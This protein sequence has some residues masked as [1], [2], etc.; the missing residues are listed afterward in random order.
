MMTDHP[1]P[2]APGRAA[3]QSA[4]DRGFF[5]IMAIAITLTVVIGF[6]VSFARPQTAFANAPWH[7]HLHAAVFSL[8]I[9]LY[10]LQN[11]LVVRGGFGLHRA[12]GVFGAG[13]VLVMVAVGIHTTVMALALHRVPPFFPPGV[14]LVLDVT[15]VL[16]FA[17]LTLAAVG[18]RRNAAWHK[19]LMLCGTI[20]VMSPALGRLLPMPLLGAWASWAVS[21]TMLLYVLVAVLYDRARRGR[22]HPAYA[23]GAGA[24][25]LTQL[26]IAGLGFAPPIL[27]FA[28][29]LQG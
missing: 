20:M 15:G 2:I 6:S 11:A 5:L 22:V 10:L 14:F 1:T 26:L 21:G 9:A 12:L 19:R 13:W 24:I 23:W 25:I 8:W 7:V 3:T 4:S 27:A 28:A 17:I 29:R 16:T 18:L